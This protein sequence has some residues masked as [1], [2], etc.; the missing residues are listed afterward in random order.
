MLVKHITKVHFTKLEAS[1]VARML[2]RLA[3][4]SNLIQAPEIY[5][6]SC[7]KGQISFF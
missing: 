6:S 1:I 7:Q 4:S 5:V 3:C 2:I